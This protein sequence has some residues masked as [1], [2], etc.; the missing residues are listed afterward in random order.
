M[1][2]K[3]PVAKKKKPPKK[4]KKLLTAAEVTTLINANNK[5][6]LSTELLLCLIWK[7]SGFNPADKNA[8]SSATGL[9]QMTKGAVEQVNKSTP[10]GIHFKHSDMTDPAKNIDCGT[11]Y[12]QMRI[13]WANSVVKDGIDGFGTGAHYSDNILDCERCII[14]TPADTDPCL[15]AIHS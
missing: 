6:T 12:L 9:M 15:A 5:S 3:K 11:R 1:K 10:K 14:K 8:S 7:E 13:D 2:K 4:K